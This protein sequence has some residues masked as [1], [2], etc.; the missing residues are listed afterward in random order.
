MNAELN[1]PVFVIGLERLKTERYQRV[2]NDLARIG[3]DATLWPAVDGA[4][5]IKLEPGEA[6]NRFHCYNYVFFGLTLPRAAI[7]CCLSHWRLWKH[8][9]EKNAFER[10]AVFEDDVIFNATHFK[11]ALTSIAKL[12]Q[13]FEY[14]QLKEERRA[15]G[16]GGQPLTTGGEHTLCELDRYF[17]SGTYG[18][19]ISRQGFKKLAPALTPIN[20]TADV[21]IRDSR[22][23]VNLRVWTVAPS[24]CRVDRAVASSVSDHK[25]ALLLG[26]KFVRFALLPARWIYQAR[27]TADWTVA[28]RG[29]TGGLAYEKA[30]FLAAFKAIKRSAAGRLIYRFLRGG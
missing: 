22:A 5:P 2:L 16:G 4:Q 28:R 3:V 8:A 20:R 27:I 10:I 11:E 18:Y 21:A 9:F 7:G 1:M 13:A 24:L 25:R 19:A 30:L 29:A 23:K 15:A 6:I 26:R 12:D 14:I 17:M